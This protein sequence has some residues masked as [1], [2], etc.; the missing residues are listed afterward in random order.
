MHPDHV[1]DLLHQDHLQRIETARLATHQA[2]RPPR[3]RPAPRKRRRPPERNWVALLA[4]TP[5]T[6]GVAVAR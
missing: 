4:W 3:A 1:L 5:V 6:V 2:A